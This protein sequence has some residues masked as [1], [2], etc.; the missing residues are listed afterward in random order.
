MIRS[1]A[2]EDLSVCLAVIR[3][4]FA[5]V[6]EE[7]GLTP[8]NCPTHTSFM[9]LEK[10]QKHFDWGWQMFMLIEGDVSVGFYG[11][12]E[13]EN[14]C[15]ELHNLAVLPE[16]RHHG[17]GRQLLEDAKRRVL[18]QG[19]NALEIGIIEEHTVLKNWYIANGFVPVGTKTFPHL[20]F[21]AG[22][23]TCPLKTE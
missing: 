13:K 16:Y 20:P 18:E 8:E 9:P 22:Y 14:G 10:L 12:S 21:T 23:L 19:G 15:F 17:Y 1:A 5:T 11:L 4:S 6:A 7:F 3:R 2:F